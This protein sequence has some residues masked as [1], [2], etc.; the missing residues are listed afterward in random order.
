MMWN[1]ILIFWNKLSI[2]SV[3]YICLIGI[4]LTFWYG[5]RNNVKQLERLYQQSEAGISAI[6][7]EYLETI[8]LLEEVIREYE[9]QLDALSKSI[10]K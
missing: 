5:E 6:E 8:T 10:D 4:L 9:L 7:A 1:K 2:A 3:I